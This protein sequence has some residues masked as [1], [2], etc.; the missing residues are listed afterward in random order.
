MIRRLVRD[1]NVDVEIVGAP[2]VREADGLALSSRN[3]NLS[4]EARREATGLVRA[5]DS[6]ERAVAGGERD[7]VRILS[8]VRREIGRSRLARIDYAEL[9]DP[10]SLAQAPQEIDGP[11]LLALAVFLPAKGGGDGALVRLIDNRVLHPQ[12]AWEDSA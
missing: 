8:R 5:L 6:A 2:I 12:S 11:V 4:A 10:R 9:R 7:V 1:L 3:A